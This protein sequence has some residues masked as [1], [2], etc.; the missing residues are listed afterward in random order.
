M[1]P[2]ARRSSPSAYW[3]ASGATFTRAASNEPWS[4]GKKNGNDDLR[5]DVERQRLGRGRLRASTRTRAGRH[6]GRR[7]R[8]DRLDARRRRGLAVAGNGSADGDLTGEG[9]HRRYADRV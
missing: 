7:V 5:A 9:S 4:D 3:S 8:S 6:D 2:C 1:P